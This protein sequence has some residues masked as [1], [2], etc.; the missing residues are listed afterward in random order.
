MERTNEKN[1]A[2]LS[3]LVLSMSMLVGGV[4][5]SAANYELV[6]Y[7]VPSRDP[8]EIQEANKPLSEMLKA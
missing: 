7:F 3:V 6:I 4:S 1:L 2:L 8:P 5:K